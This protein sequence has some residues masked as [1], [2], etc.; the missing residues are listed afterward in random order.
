MEKISVSESY[1]VIAQQ[2][3]PDFYERYKYLFK[4]PENN[5]RIIEVFDSKLFP[6]TE[7]L[8]PEIE[9]EK[10]N[11]EAKKAETRKLL[12]EKTTKLLGKTDMDIEKYYVFK[13]SKGENPVEIKRHPVDRIYICTY[14][15]GEKLMFKVPKIEVKLKSETLIPSKLI[16]GKDV[17]VGEN[18]IVYTITDDKGLL[19]FEDGKLDQDKKIA[20]DSYGTKYAFVEIFINNNPFIRP[21]NTKE[22]VL[23]YSDGKFDLIGISDIPIIKFYKKLPTFYNNIMNNPKLNVKM[24]LKM[25]DKNLL[26]NLSENEEN[27]KMGRFTGGGSTKSGFRVSEDA[28]KEI[29]EIHKKTI[30]Q[31]SAYYIIATEVYRLPTSKPDRLVSIFESAIT[32]TGDFGVHL[33]NE[34]LLKEF[35]FLYNLEFQTFRNQI[36]ERIIFNKKET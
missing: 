35:R 7:S 29:K 28:K 36:R 13:N 3:A 5:K 32:Q 15:S 27:V 16:I 25:K 19:K 12:L 2:E 23:Q 33:G 9:T 1:A 6:V 4:N 26:V 10:L 8:K 31:A 30:K 34:T 22:Y 17:D 11:E 18:Q 24:N 20:E 14:E 21:F